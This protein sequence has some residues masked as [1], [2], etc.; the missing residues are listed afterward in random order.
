VD[1]K[2]AR[3]WMEKLAR[4]ANARDLEA[5]MRLISRDVQVFGVPGVEVIG[6][7]DWRAQCAHEFAEGILKSFSYA[8]LEVVMM[9]PGRVVFETRETVEGSDGTVHVMDVEVVLTKEQ[10]GEWRVT[11]ENVKNVASP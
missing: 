6:Y 7:E 4:T 3:E 11:Q 9:T 5:H 8:G 2:V 10:D 1:S